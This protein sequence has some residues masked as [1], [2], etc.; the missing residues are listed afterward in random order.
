MYLTYMYTYMYS[1]NITTVCLK[2]SHTPVY[3]VQ[4]PPTFNFLLSF[5]SA[6][7]VVLLTPLTF[8]RLLSEVFSVCSRSITL[9]MALTTRS[10]SA[11]L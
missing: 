6:I 8:A 4:Q 2:V 10:N 3:Y 11:A 5:S 1:V 9:R 7:R